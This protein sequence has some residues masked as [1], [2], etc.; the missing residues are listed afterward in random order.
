MGN[1][2]MISGAIKLLSLFGAT[3]FICHA[4]ASFQLPLGVQGRIFFEEPTLDEQH[5]SVASLSAAPKWTDEFGD[6]HIFTVDLF[7]RWDQGDDNRTHADVREFSYLKAWENFEISLGVKKVFWGVMEFQNLVNIVNQAD[8]V[9]N[10][11]EKEKL[12]QPMAVMSLLSSFGKLEVYGM[13]FFRERTFPGRKGRPRTV[14]RIDGDLSV[15]EDER[16]FDFA[17]RWSHSYGPM[18]WAMSYFNGTS[19]EPV[20]QLTSVNGESVLIPIYDLISQFGLET[21]ITAGPLALKLESIVREGEDFSLNS[22]GRFVAR[23]D[24]V[25]TAVG[26]ELTL[27]GCF[28]LGCE[29]GLMAEYYYNSLD[30][31]AASVYQNDFFG[32]LRISANNVWDTQI[33]TGITTDIESGA[34]LFNFDLSS[35]IYDNWKFKFRAVGFGNI[36]N[37]DPLRPFEFDNHV[38]LDLI[39]YIDF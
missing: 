39:R 21:V 14:P 9:E 29:V 30:T 23:N 31:D 1:T 19:R 11:S 36:G 18:D 2:V 20:F 27:P 7:A 12:G 6:G 25:A 13:T 34:S 24:F 22:Q 8:V 5:G 33:V 17:A 3:F 37:E 26:G 15:F 16:D 4:K 38:Q 10:L 35:R 28:G 32:G